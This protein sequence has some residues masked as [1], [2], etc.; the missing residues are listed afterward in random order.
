[1][2]LMMPIFARAT[3]KFIDILRSKA[4]NGTAEIDV[5]EWMS[6]L[7]LELVGQGSLGYSFGTLNENSNNAYAEAL[8]M[9]A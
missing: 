7:A 5:L 2:R 4:A 9:I 6:R 3:D 1:M 8:K